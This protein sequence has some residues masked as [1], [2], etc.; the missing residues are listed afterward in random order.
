MERNEEKRVETYIYCIYS[1]ASNYNIS[2]I[3]A[4]SVR[5]YLTN[6]SKANNEVKLC[7]HIM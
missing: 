3:G 5:V 1:G 7:K 4:M 2:Y 6:T